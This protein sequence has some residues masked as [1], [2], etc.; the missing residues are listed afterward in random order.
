[1]NEQM[2]GDTGLVVHR[3]VE[4]I[5]KRSR[6]F[7]PED[8]GVSLDDAQWNLGSRPTARSFTAIMTRCSYKYARTYASGS[9]HQPM[10]ALLVAGL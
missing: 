5:T 1:M 2:M 8:S 7:H 6:L 3:S 9:M 4:S 10:L